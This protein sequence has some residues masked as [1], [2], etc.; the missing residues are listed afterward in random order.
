VKPE[1]I[2]LPKISDPRGNLSVI[3]SSVHIPFEI[4]R[5][6]LIHDVPGGQ[7]RGG[8]AYKKQ[9]EFIISL[10]GSFDVHI[11]DGDNKTNFSLNRSYYGLLVPNMFWRSMVNFS[12]NSLCLVLSSTHFDVNDYIR[13]YDLF[14]KLVHGSLN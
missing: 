4:K 12:T 3:E 5:T 6:Y 8:H 14:L 2:K 13:D 7:A 1:I 10:S 11:D 9:L